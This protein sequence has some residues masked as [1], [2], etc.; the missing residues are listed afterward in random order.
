MK[1]DDDAKRRLARE[2]R[3]KLP[4]LIEFGDEQDVRRY[5]KAWNPKLTDEQLEGVVKLFLDAKH[6]RAHLQ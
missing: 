5:A 4:F 2:I 6:A 1:L 3:N